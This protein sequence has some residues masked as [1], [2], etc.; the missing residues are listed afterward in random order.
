MLLSRRSALLGTAATVSLATPLA[1]AEYLNR[2]DDAYLVDLYRRWE[3]LRDQVNNYIRTT[4]PVVSNEEFDALCGPVIDMQRDI[5]TTPAGTLRGIAVK[6][7]AHVAITYDPPT[8]LDQ[9]L[10][11]LW[12]QD[13]DKL[14]VASIYRD[15][16]RLTGEA[17]S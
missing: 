3:T 8:F 16:E 2:A 9:D 7:W 10:D 13:L 12:G 14:Y 17:S 4:V 15:L 6:F 1:A 5:A 11:H